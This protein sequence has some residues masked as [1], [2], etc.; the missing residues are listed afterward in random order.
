MLPRALAI[1]QERHVQGEKA[2]QRLTPAHPLGG[3]KVAFAFESV[4]LLLQA[5]R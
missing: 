1:W 5:V 3:Q 4:Q 2:R